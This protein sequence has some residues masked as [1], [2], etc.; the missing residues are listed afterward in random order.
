[1][2]EESS[3]PDGDDRGELHPEA[4]SKTT[5]RSANTLRG[6]VSRASWRIPLVVSIV[7]IGTSIAGF[8]LTNYAPERASWYWVLI[9]PAFAAVPLWHTWTTIRSDGKTNWPIVRKQIYHW[10]A[11]LIAMQ[12]L[13]VLIRSGN[14]DGHSGGL[15]A[16]LL[17][18][19]TCS[20]VGISFDWVFIVVG[21]IL[22]VAVLVAAWFQEYLWLVLLALGLAFVVLLLVQWLARRQGAD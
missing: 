1:M 10:I 5:H 20:N 4:A 7:L 17:M 3:K 15:V 8:A 9:L 11:L 18:A 21:A 22:T 19:L 6:A 12:V 16:L 14:I 2:P 13:F